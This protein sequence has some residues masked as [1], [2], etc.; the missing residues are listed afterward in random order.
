M[1]F[2]LHRMNA[3][4]VQLLYQSPSF[5]VPAMQFVLKNMPYHQS[6]KYTQ[7]SDAVYVMLFNQSS[8]SNLYTRSF[9]V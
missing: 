3:Y 1:T 2:P 5:N 8:Y 7:Y 9:G 6:G 4:V